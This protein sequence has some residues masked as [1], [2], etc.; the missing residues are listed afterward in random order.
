MKGRSLSFLLILQ[1]VWIGTVFGVGTWW[2]VVIQRQAEKIHSLEVA[3]GANGPQIQ[4]QWDRTQRMIRWE[5]GTFALLILGITTL[6]FFIYWRD[7]LRNRSIRAFFASLTHELKTPLTSIRLQ[8]ESISENLSDPRMHRLL[9]DASRLE[10]QVE[11]T[12]ELARVEGG[13]SVFV[14]PLQLKGIVERELRQWKD[15]YRHLK[16]EANIDDVVALADT[17]SLQIILRNLLENSFRHVGRDQV[18]VRISSHEEDG[19]PIFKFQD[20][21]GTFKGDLSRLGRIFQKG[22][23]SSGAGVGLYLVQ[24]LMKKMGGEAQFLGGSGFTVNLKFK[25][26]TLDGH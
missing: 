22:E 24:T 20:N 1:V 8:A 7:S 19:C 25:G 4:E 2:G 10:G 21:G 5:S 17:G 14:Q 16:V 18:V 6:L 9:E 15:T 12:L 26:A 23:K 13:G 11:R 3:A